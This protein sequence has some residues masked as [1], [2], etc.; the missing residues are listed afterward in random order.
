[1]EMRIGQ[2]AVP[3]GGGP[4]FKMVRQQN[5]FSF[6]FGIQNYNPAHYG[7]A[8]P[9]SLGSGKSNELIGKDVSVLGYVSVFNNDIARI[10]FPRTRGDGPGT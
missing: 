5:D 3:N 9:G 7:V 2:A 8:V 4:K 6:V 1:M 10:G